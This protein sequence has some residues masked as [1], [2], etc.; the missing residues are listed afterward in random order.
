MSS[1]G[2]MGASLFGGGLLGGGGGSM[3][4]GGGGTT[5]FSSIGQAFTMPQAAF[6]A[7]Q[8]SGNMIY[9]NL[10]NAYLGG[11]GGGGVGSVRKF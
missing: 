7:P 4:L 1:I 11:L 10:T 6:G 9:D 5:A 2:G 3:N 8:Y